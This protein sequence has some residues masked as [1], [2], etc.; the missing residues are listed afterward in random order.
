MNASKIDLGRLPRR[1]RPRMRAK[2]KGPA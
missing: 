1:R 2:A